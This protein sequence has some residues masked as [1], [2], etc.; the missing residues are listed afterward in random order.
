MDSRKKLKI[1]QNLKQEA[2]RL[3]QEGNAHFQSE[4]YPASHKSYRQALGIVSSLFDHTR[5]MKDQNIALDDVKY[6]IMTQQGDSIEDPLYFERDVKNL[7]LSLISN[8]SLVLYRSKRY[9]EVI[10]LC[11]SILNAPSSLRLDQQDVDSIHDQH[12]PYSKNDGSLEDSKSQLYKWGFTK[13]YFRRGLAY[14]SIQQYHMAVDDLQTCLS[15]MNTLNTQ[16]FNLSKSKEIDETKTKLLRLKSYIDQ[17]ENNQAYTSGSRSLICHRP[18]PDQ[19]REIIFALLHQQNCDAN[20]KSSVKVGESYF[21]IDYKWWKKWCFHVN[22]TAATETTVPI[23]RAI[24]TLQLHIPTND[25][26]DDINMYPI[27][28]NA[29]F[30]DDSI[31]SSDCSS[32]ENQKHHYYGPEPSNIDNKALFID[33]HSSASHD[34]FLLQWRMK[35]FGSNFDETDKRIVCSYLKPNLV[36]GYHYEVLPREVYAALRLWYGELTSSV[37][38]R[39]TNHPKDTAKVVLHLY[40]THPNENQILNSELF[41]PYSGRLGFVNL[42]NTCFMNSALQ[43]LSHATPLTRYFLMEIFSEDINE[44]N[45]LG[46]GGKLANSYALMVK[47]VWSS[48][49]GGSYSPR[50][51]KRSISLFA[52]RFAGSSQHDSQEFLAFLLDGLHEDLNRIKNPPY[53]EKEDIHTEHNLAIAGAKAWDDHCK[54]NQSIIMDSFYGQFKSTCV[55]PRCKQTSVSFDVFNHISLEIPSM[56][57]FG[58]F[59]PIILFERQDTPPRRYGVML[60]KNSTIADMKVALCRLSDVPVERL[61]ICDVYEASIYEILDDNKFISSIN[62]DDVIAAFNIDPY[63]SSK[64]HFISSHAKDEGNT[65]IVPSFPL[66]TSCD[67]N[68]T[69]DQ[70]YQVFQQQLIYLTL[71]S[72]TSF[73]LKLLDNGG[74]LLYIFPDQYG[75][76][77]CILP[78]TR[79]TLAS[80]LY[81]DLSK[82]FIF[83]NVEW[84]TDVAN[85]LNFEYYENHPSYEK[86][87][88]TSRERSNIGQKLSLDD[89]FDNFTN[90]ERLDEENKWFCSKCKDHVRAEKTMILWRLPNILIVHLKRFEFKHSLRRDKLETFVDFPLK[91]LNMKKYCGSNLTND[92]VVDSTSASY[93]LFGVVNHYGRLGFGHYTAFAR[94]WNE[95][96]IEREWML[97]D[98]SSVH[99]CIEDEVISNSAYILFYRRRSFV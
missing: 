63:H 60:P 98:D 94:R 45:P 70:I 13:L 34:I 6:S 83:L 22:F 21:L 84:Q 16:I 49:K 59:I 64:I 79:E 62:R 38:I 46:T 48:K 74:N 11:N 67:V 44:S 52:P 61:A 65:K 73:N 51:L 54:R 57:R 53:I 29:S 78:R 91:D 58:Q 87:I 41:N 36:R 35:I 81:D 82:S 96:G 66:F 86:T 43:C 50:A 92:F 33:S 25:D 20:G 30:D 19:Q 18:D 28:N 24:H 26:K 39:T 56:N 40:D 85:E 3:K 14:E 12:F 4:N 88:V 9:N 2:E 10:E 93:D 42:G 23:K 76:M 80:F 75:S 27:N 8:I 95:D 99:P 90:P 37:C 15:T 71:R 31:H 89:C 17:S 32:T 7:Q 69:C 72:G 47:S 77:S 1:L 68:A 97:F 55:C 5:K